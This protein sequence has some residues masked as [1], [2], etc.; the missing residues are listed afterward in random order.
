[1][2]HI[3]DADLV[4]LRA[5]SDAATPPPWRAMIEGRDHESGDTFILIGESGHYADD[6]YL[7]RARAGEPSWPA[8]HVDHDVVATSRTY[9][10]LLIEE[11]E[12]LRKQL[13][14]R[15]R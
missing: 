4:R 6:I 8:S 3:S 9:L 12:R 10:P 1:M 15:G 2:Q 7:S 5:I 13:A 14:D 11:M